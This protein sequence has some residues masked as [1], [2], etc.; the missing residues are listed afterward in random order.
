MRRLWANPY[1]SVERVLRG[2]RECGCSIAVPSDRTVGH[3]VSANELLRR[4]RHRRHVHR[5]AVVAATAT[6]RLGKASSTPHD[7]SI[8]FFDAIAAAAESLGLEL[9]ELL[10]AT[11]ARR[12]ARRSAST[13]WSRARSRASALFATK[14]HGDTIRIMNDA[15]RMLGQPIE[16]SST[17]RRSSSRRRS[18]AASTSSRSPSASTRRRGRRRPRSRRRLHRAIDCSIRSASRRS[19]S[20]SCGLS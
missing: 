19:R 9:R 18:S 7:F 3:E 17:T 16:G 1:L 8:G 2:Q 13:R 6:R 12:T 5:R 11:T 4:R 14:G 20:R 15:G 10:A